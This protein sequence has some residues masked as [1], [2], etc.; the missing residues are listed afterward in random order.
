MSDRSGWEQ[1]IVTGKP[2]SLFQPWPGPP[3]FGLIY[4][5]TF[6]QESL[7]DNKTFSH[8]LNQLR[9]ACVC[10][11]GKRS[12]WADRICAEFDPHISSAKYVVDEVLPFIRRRFELPE[13]SLGLLG[14]SMG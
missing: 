6:N 8:W 5:H 9:L 7:V 12:W 3:R 1:V 2:T 13:R 10:P 14:V 4:L 11:Q